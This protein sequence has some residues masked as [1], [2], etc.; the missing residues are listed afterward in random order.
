YNLVSS[1]HWALLNFTG[2]SGNAVEGDRADSGMPRRFGLYPNVP[3]PF[4]PATT[5]SFFLDQ[6]GP[7]TLRIYNALGQSVAVLADHQTFGVGSHSMRWNAASLP[8]GVYACR[9]ETRN[10]TAH[11]KMLLLR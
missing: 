8:S 10:G 7:V 2:E 3:N 6:S 5:I 11:Q 9:L 4:N 1:S